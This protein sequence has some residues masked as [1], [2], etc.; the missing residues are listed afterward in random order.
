MPDQ[1]PPDRYK[2]EMPQIPGVHPGS[3]RGPL[4]NPAVRMVGALLVVLLVVFIGARWML[5]PKHIEAPP[6]EPPPRIEVPSPAPDPNAALPHATEQ[7][8]GIATVAEMAQPWSS[9]QFF[10]RNGLTGEN[11]PALLIRLPGGSASQDSAYWAFSLNAPYGNCQMEYVT[12]L[13][14][15]KTDYDFKAAKH[16]MVGNPCNRTV[17][18]PTKLT[19]LPG[20]VWVRG[21]IAQG[22][23]L[24]P[25][26][27]IEVKVKGKSI[28]AIRM[29]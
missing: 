26:L 2:A 17:F 11:V 22:S 7:D 14:K 8:P 15:L 1:S 5:R 13:D 25:P 20:N 6:A 27:G 23:D 24:R 9:K 4:S 10:M 29:E 21:A 18:D 16:P 3:N 28:Q 12:D 19:N